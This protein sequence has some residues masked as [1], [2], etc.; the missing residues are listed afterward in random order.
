MTAVLEALEHVSDVQ[1]TDLSEIEAEAVELKR[2]SEVLMPVEAAAGEL[3]HTRMLELQEESTRA[4]IADKTGFKILSKEVLTWRQ[5]YT[6]RPKEKFRQVTLRIPRLALIG[7][8]W[9]SPMLSIATSNGRYSGGTVQW[10]P[11]ELQPYYANVSNELQWLQQRIKREPVL[12]FSYTGVIPDET[13]EKIQE[14]SK[15]PSFR[16]NIYLLCDAPAEQWKL[17]TTP[18]P[19]PPDPIVVGFAGG[20]LWVIDVFDPTP[21]EQYVS[22]EFSTQPALMPG[23]LTS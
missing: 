7:T 10:L 12:S 8:E 17:D 15:I 9:N 4:V 18:I 19:Q 14:A 21:I 3:I 20:S 5:D 13:R 11:V 2:R 6:Y 16:S 23:G 1:K 22:L